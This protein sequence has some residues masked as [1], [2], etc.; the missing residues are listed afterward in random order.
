METPWIYSFVLFFDFLFLLFLLFAGFYFVYFLFNFPEMRKLQHS[1]PQILWA[2]ITVNNSSPSVLTYSTSSKS[3]FPQSK[4][5]TEGKSCLI[6]LYT[7]CFQQWDEF[8]KAETYSACQTTPSVW[9]HLFL[10]ALCLWV[11]PFLLPGNSRYSRRVSWLTWSSK[12]S[13]LDSAF[14]LSLVLVDRGDHYYFY[15]SLEFCFCLHEWPIY[16]TNPF[17]YFFIT[18]PSQFFQ[19]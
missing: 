11:S 4:A 6:F 12:W 5:K 3:E 13:C 16:S 9:L 18:V 2:V 1:A 7:I 8:P 19:Y 14:I 15:C 10:L 17:I